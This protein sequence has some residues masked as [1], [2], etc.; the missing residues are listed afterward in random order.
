MQ[1]FF[2]NRGLIHEIANS[3]ASQATHTRQNRHNILFH[4]V[5]IA[6]YQF[7]TFKMFLPTANMSTK[8]LLITI[9]L[10]LLIAA[11]FVRIVLPWTAKHQ[12]PRP[13][14]ITFLHIHDD[15]TDDN[16]GDLVTAESE[17]AKQEPV[18][19]PSK[20]PFVCEF[21]P[22]TDFCAE[23]AALKNPW[24]Y[25]GPGMPR[26]CQPCFDALAK[27]KKAA[28]AKPKKIITRPNKRALDLFREI[29]TK[30]LQKEKKESSTFYSYTNCGLRTRMSKHFVREELPR[31]S[32]TKIVKDVRFNLPAHETAL[33]PYQSR[34][35]VPYRTPNYS[36]DPDM[37]LHGTAQVQGFTLEANSALLWGPSD[38]LPKKMF[39]STTDLQ[40][41]QVPVHETALVVYTPPMNMN[42]KKPFLLWTS[43]PCFFPEED[44]CQPLTK[45]FSV[46]VCD[47]PSVEGVE[48]L[49]LG[50]RPP[51]DALPDASLLDP[52][53]AVPS[54]QP[55]LPRRN[56]RRVKSARCHLAQVI[57][58]CC[59]GQCI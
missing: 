43:N 55:F 29:R 20:S 23:C 12:P 19:P 8:D 16:D 15:L 33:V 47:L 35:I 30:R 52:L 45:K 25:Q 4:P 7:Q 54:T 2:T 17:E 49:K 26:T 10:E 41:V 32:I 59:L 18:A 27:K 21:L 36:I 22:P 51:V 48:D 1:T 24:K 42:Q 44:W 38:D 46:R 13:I 39:M 11:W 37:F 6:F 57:S 40:K 50:Y 28:A 58:V 5:E 34:A 53:A 31:R 9:A 14:N 3:I 56:R